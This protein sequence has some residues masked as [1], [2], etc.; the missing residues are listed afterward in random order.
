[1]APGAPGTYGPDW[2]TASSAWSAGPFPGAERAGLDD[3]V[4]GQ[5]CQSLSR[6]PTRQTLVWTMMRTMDSDTHKA[7][8]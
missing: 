2:L 1:M 3:S 7:P 6:A 4:M 8:P 5:K